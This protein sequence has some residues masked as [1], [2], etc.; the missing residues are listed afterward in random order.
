M[1]HRQSENV[2]QLLLITGP[3]QAQSDFF[4]FF[5]KKTSSLATVASGAEGS[6]GL[7]NA[8]AFELGEDADGAGH[9]QRCLLRIQKST[10]EPPSS[11]P[12][13]N[14]RG[15]LNNKEP[16][17]PR[18][19]HSRS[20]YIIK[21]GELQCAF[22]PAATQTPL[23]L[24]PLPGEKGWG[25]ERRRGRRGIFSSCEKKNRLITV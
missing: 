16:I 10:S 19:F 13:S 22:L 11:I 6:D 7:G 8:G 21:V 20:L 14:L 18:V 15:S 9:Y 3:V 1:C 4:F 23:F 25:R 2:T 12:C 24:F 17:G 5:F